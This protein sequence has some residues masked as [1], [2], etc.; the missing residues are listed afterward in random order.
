MP[1]LQQACQRLSLLLRPPAP[2]ILWETCA[3]EVPGQTDSFL[4][5]IKLGVKEAAADPDALLLF[6]GGKTR[7]CALVW[8]CQPMPCMPTGCALGCSAWGRIGITIHAAAPVSCCRDAGPRAEGEG[9]WLVAEAAKWCVRL[10]AKGLPSGQCGGGG[11]WAHQLSRAPACPARWRP[12]PLVAPS[13][14]VV[15]QPSHPAHRGGPPPLPPPLLSR[16]ARYGQPEVRGRAFTEDRARDSFE[17][18]LF[19]LCRFFELTGRYPEFVVVSWLG[20]SGPGGAP[21]APPAVRG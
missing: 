7:R 14:L 3:Q 9:Y 13:P 1:R 11:A 10:P 19:G 20:A 17:N 16:A 5:H 6:S 15:Q 8:P 21:P 12:H 4:E 18:L 2:A